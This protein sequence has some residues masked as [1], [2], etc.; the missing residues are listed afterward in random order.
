MDIFL[1]KYFELN[2]NN[3]DLEIVN[4]SKFKLFKSSTYYITG[5]LNKKNIWLVDIKLDIDLDY[6]IKLDI[7]RY[8]KQSFDINIEDLNTEYTCEKLITFIKCINDTNMLH[9]ELSNTLTGYIP[10][11]CKDCFITS[12][13][14]A[15]TDS[16]NFVVDI[17]LK[18]CF[19][20]IWDPRMETTLKPLPGFI[21]KLD[22]KLF[23][24]ICSGFNLI[25]NLCNDGKTDYEI[26]SELYKTSWLG[27]EVIRCALM[28][29]NI[30]SLES[31]DTERI[32]GKSGA[33]IFKVKYNN[34][35]ISNKF[36]SLLS[37]SGHMAFH[38]SSIINWYSIVYNGLFVAR[39]SLISNGAAYGTGVYLSNSS[40]L[41]IGYC[42]KY[43]TTSKNIIIGVFQVDEPIDKFKKTMNIYVVPDETKICL[44]YLIYMKQTSGT[45]KYAVNI[46][47]YFINGEV[48]K[49]AQI[50]ANVM[51]KAWS[52]RVMKEIRELHARDGIMCDDGLRYVV[53]DSDDMNII[54]LSIAR[55]TFND[56]ELGKDM[57][58]MNVETI[59]MEIRIPANYPFEPPF[60]RI[61]NPKF[62]FRTGH[63]TIGGSICMDLL[64][65]Q[66]WV[67]SMSISKIMVTIVQNMIAGGARLEPGGQKYIYSLQEAQ[68][69]FTRMLATHKGE[70]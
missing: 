39:G 48:T 41:S 49:E 69:A 28:N 4:D 30:F 42:H 9:S 43:A 34:P 68:N 27:Y 47:K 54:I 35:A 50:T 5:E 22:N 61:L 56:C 64:T 70:W 20:G 52:Q 60:I 7:I 25:I 29:F 45:T 19:S 55:D 24:R 44:R 65:K 53:N 3:N 18:E 6:E 16:Y 36:D 1:N 8:V 12:W 15:H 66:G 51:S 32:I 38:G 58:K 13:K 26:E 11:K 59:K 2:I 31:M 10:V 37:Q 14:R 21:T 63:I 23:D 33:S 17:L 46:D 62:A 57:D 40:N 67:P